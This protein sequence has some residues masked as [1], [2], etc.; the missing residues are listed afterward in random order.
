MDGKE[1]GDTVGCDGD[2]GP[3]I[4]TVRQVF[5]HYQLGSYLYSTVPIFLGATDRGINFN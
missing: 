1:D 5:P 4:P 3:F 2:G